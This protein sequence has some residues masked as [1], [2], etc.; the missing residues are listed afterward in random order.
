MPVSIVVGGQY[1]SEGKGKVAHYFAKEQGAT[2]AV[3]CGGPNSGHTV[4]VNETPYIFQHLPTASIIPSVKNFLCAGSYIHIK[5]LQNEIAKINL[6]QDKLFID[7]HAVII[8]DNH[9]E[10]ESQEKLTARIGSTGCGLG[11]A[12]MARIQ[13]R[14]D[15]VLAKDV[16]E[17]QPY[18]CNVASK[19]REALSQNERI[20]IEGT[21]GFGL[22]V[23]H[24]P[25]Y[26]Y[27]T[28]RDTTAAGFLSECGLSPLD[29]DD[30]ILVIRAFPI[31]VAG[32][33]G[34]LDNETTWEA[35]QHAGK[36]ATDLTELTTVTK[37]PRR[38]AHFSPDIVLKAIE[39]NHPTK[40]V[41]NHID[42]F[43]TGV[44]QAHAEKYI[45]NIEEKLGRTMDFLGFNPEDLAVRG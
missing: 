7:E 27:A 23:L 9:K 35:I 38:V 16:R 11:A 10:L 43:E 15:I 31:R 40:I 44:T 6:P 12:V 42:L 21:Q 34:P 19:L 18:I 20:I 33:S 5:T 29:V 17:L 8:N 39:S 1:G 24:S 2:C 30:I 26:P 4:V 13:R 25:H 36:H 28:S 41:L 14:E 37:R 22:S 3:R 32:N 45:R